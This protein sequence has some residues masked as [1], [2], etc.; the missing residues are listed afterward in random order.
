MS[1]PGAADLLRST[2]LMADGP[3]VWG[4]PVPVRSPGVFVIELPVPLATAPIELTRVGKWIEKV[5]GLR[6]DGERPTSRA[7]VARIASF[8]LPA[9]PV[10]YVG[11]SPT[12]ISARVASLVRHE[13][14][15][16]RPHAPG[17]WL[18]TLTV[19]D[20]VRI[21]WAVTDAAEEYEDGVLSAFSAGVS[22]EERRGLPD[23]TVVLP[24]A[25]TTT[26]SGERKAHG[27]TGAVLAD[28]R[29]EPP[30]TRVVD[31]PPGDAEGVPDARGSGKV[32]R[33]N[34]TPPRERTV[35]APRVAAAR[36]S[37]A[38]ATTGGT[39]APKA[40]PRPQ[41][42]P[43]LLSADGLERLR[44]ELDELTRIRRPQVVARIRAAKEL[45]DLK[46]N[47]D[48]TAAREEQSFLEGRVQ[49]LEALLREAVVVD[50]AS[51]PSVG[52]GS[53]VVVDVEGDRMT[54]SIVS[55]SEASPA[56]GRISYASPVG[57]AL[58]GRAPGDEVEVQA[59]R[60]AVHYRIIE[61]G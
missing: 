58:M 32:R 5:P 52:I 37:A 3:V 13:L 61:V 42:A 36:S 50:A 59:P 25:N 19:L 8:W 46:E 43:T 31:L 14:G 17:Q 22:E 44:A 48:Y 41:S 34:V 16:R 24:F 4:R 6:L 26:P 54:Y 47:A 30:P 7:L 57:S 18:K 49:A 11:S 51:G 15:D 40:P 29:V 28:D 55:P 60:G 33:T 9:Q 1:G 27:I 35:R 45:G 56:Q 23:R 53:R 2:G 38:R 10:L 12:S 20:R 21:W 39:R